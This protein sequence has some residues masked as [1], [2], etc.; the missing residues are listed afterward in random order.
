MIIWEKLNAV[1]FGN[2]NEPIA[3]VNRNSESV[4][5][6]KKNDA[7]DA[8]RKASLEEMIVEMKARLGASAITLS[9]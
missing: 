4:E 2:S 6:V 3:E 9:F 8:L 1:L 7:H 5:E